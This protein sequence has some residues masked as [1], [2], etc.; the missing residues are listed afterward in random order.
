MRSSSLFIDNLKD[1]KISYRTTIDN[2]ISEFYVP[3]LS[4]SV[5]YDRAVGYFSSNIL[6]A[7]IDGLEKF[8]EN[9]GKMRLLISPFISFKDGKALVDAVDPRYRT[10]K[11]MNDLFNQYRLGNEN[12]QISTQILYKMITSR[13]LEIKVVV[14]KTS[15]GLFH[16]KTSVFYDKVGAMISTSG[17][18]N[19]TEN[20]VEANLES[21]N[22]FCS[23][24]NGQ[25]GYV[26]QSV[27]DFEE[28]WQDELEEYTSVP[29][30]EA[31]DED[32]LQ[33]YE[34]SASLT[35]L[36]DQKKKISNTETIK[37]K[38]SSPLE[39]EPRK[40]QKDAAELWIEKG[41]GIIAFAT[42]T[43]K[44]KTAIYAFEKLIELNPAQI[45]LIVVPD[46]TLV[47]QWYAEMI[48][49][50]D[51]VVK[52]YSENT[53]W[54]IE[55]KN[56]INK[57]M[58]SNDEP[59]FV[60]STIQTFQGERMSKQLR[61]F[62]YDYAFIADECHNLGTDNAI[63]KLPNV[64]IRLGLSATP[65]IYMS[66]QKTEALFDYF[67]GIIA[68]Y[69]LKKAI[70]NDQLTG[71]EYYPIEVKLTEDELKKY[72]EIT[73][74]IVRMIGD[75][76]QI[77]FEG[78]SPEAQMLLFN[79][80]RIVYGASEKI[81]KLDD[82]L[83]TLKDNKHLLIYCGATS[84]ADSK[85]SSELEDQN[86]K[87]GKRQIEVVNEMLKGKNIDA[88]QYTQNE[89]DKERQDRIQW[90]KDGIIHTLVAI[91]ALDEGVDI[92]EIETGIIMAS[93]GNPREFIQRRGRLLRK[94]P[95]KSKAVIYDMVVLGEGEEYDGIN[96]SE[97]KRINEFM[98]AAINREQIYSKY[99]NYFDRYLEDI[100][101]E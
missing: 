66:P 26:N 48:N 82:L 13:I 81:S 11:S 2:V 6:V 84:I 97:V 24:K 35:E 55:L 70:K 91:K 14:P 10:K 32:I 39:F 73:L 71:Y 44:T 15:L 69:D 19:E 3:V 34:T 75:I 57:R 74:K 22:T 40:Y 16:Q 38:T 23:W 85:D 8:V 5:R 99:K 33:T 4:E 43:G 21:F 79:R 76:D 60:I 94:S 92:P 83:D 67:G 31:V 27:N 88:A 68:K 72:K 78:L 49:Y 1:I 51:N 89:N 54:D 28:I 90:Y 93:S 7:Y 47:T 96:K 18:N 12:I 80:A 46:K 65:E 61:K 37:D 58:I 17:S 95:G 53:K 41:K 30:E 62:K 25:D 45:F 64:K 77:G 20:A 50:W 100:T 98:D 87:V 101:N 86:D 36:Y 63:A 56:K 29:L 59:L 9:G 42:G 52:C